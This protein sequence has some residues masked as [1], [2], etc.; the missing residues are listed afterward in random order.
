M[1]LFVP[2]HL[3]RGEQLDLRDVVRQARLSSAPDH[4]LDWVN[5]RSDQRSAEFGDARFATIRWL[6][7]YHE[8]ALMRRYAD[9]CEGNLQ[10]LDLAFASVLGRGEDTI[11]KLRLELRRA[12]VAR[13]AD[14]A[15]GHS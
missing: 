5:K 15:A 11:K 10:R 14:D 12:L 3:L 4:L 8:L 6:Y 13:D 7:R 2:W 1:V 9:A